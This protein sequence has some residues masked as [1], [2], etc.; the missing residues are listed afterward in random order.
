[1]LIDPQRIGRFRKALDDFGYD[2]LQR[3]LRGGD[4]RAPYPPVWE[5]ARTLRKVDHRT[6][7][8]FE[9]LMLGRALPA[10]QVSGALGSGLVDDLLALEILVEGRSGRLHTRGLGVV[11]YSDRYFLAGLDGT[12]AAAKRHRRQ[13]YMGNS[14]YRLAVQLPYG[15]RF[16]SVLDIFAG[17]GLLAVLL[18]PNCERVTASDLLPE[19]VQAV[20]FN[21][22]LNG[23]EHKVEA[24][25]GSLLEPVAGEL[26][27]LVVFNAPFVAYP[28]GAQGGVLASG[29]ADGMAL[30]GPV[31]R[32]LRDHLT[33]DGWALA[34]LEGEG[35]GTDPFL[36]ERLREPVRAGKLDAELTLTARVAIAE[37]IRQIAERGA[38]IR[39]WRR[40][41]RELGATHMYA[42]IARFR[43][44]QGRIERIRAIPRM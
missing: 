6:R 21:A 18:S 36:L 39:P 11:A 32:Q 41:Y 37:R 2:R 19:A 14:S 24:R 28:P 9:V 42:A 12:Y 16:A 7:S 40:F 38:D 4:P 43:P 29:G 22:H 33:R 34:Y 17:S 20:R 8:W 5:F 26:F 35:D 3:A 13:I 30:L 23:V 44:G 10:G 31:L 1:M 25:E 27:D 15:R